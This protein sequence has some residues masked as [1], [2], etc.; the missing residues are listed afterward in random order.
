MFQ[1]P[2]LRL[3][4]P[5]NVRKSPTFHPISASLTRT[6]VLMLMTMS[7][8]TLIAQEGLS[9]KQEATLKQARSAFR[10]IKANVDLAKSTAGPGESALKGTK[11]R[12]TK[13]RLGTSATDLPKVQDL[14][15]NLPVGNADVSQFFKELESAESTIKNI[16][17]RLEGKSP[18]S[19]PKPEKEKPSKKP[20]SKPD[21][22]SMNSKS[23]TTVK[24]D[25]RQKDTLKGGQFNLREV[26]GGLRDLESIVTKYKPLKD[27]L[28]VPY[29]TI[30]QRIGV[31]QAAKR[32]LGF[33]EDTLRKL[34]DNGEGV[35]QFS[36]KIQNAKQRLNAAEEYIVRTH[37]SLQNL[38][39]PRN[40]PKL[41]ADIKRIE[42]LTQMYGNPMILLT[43]FKRSAEHVAQMQPAKK[44]VARIRSTYDRLVQQQSPE[45]TRLEKLCAYFER[46]LTTFDR[47]VASQRSQ[48]PGRI[49]QHLERCQ[50]L[51]D[52]AVK[53]KKPLFFTGGIPQELENADQKLELLSVIDQKAAKQLKQQ[54]K[55]LRV[56]LA[57]AEQRLSADIIKNNRMPEDR[58]RDTDRQ[59]VIAVAID[60]WKHQQKK[61]E[62]LAE[63]IPAE[64]WSRETMWQYS[65]GTW[66]FVDRSKLQVHLIV[67]DVKNKDQ[68]VIRPVTVI[69]NHQKGDTLIGTPIWSIKDQLTPK[70]YLLKKNVRR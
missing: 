32:K 7:A 35:N 57:S 54:I 16:Q 29:K 9:S 5:H 26:E 11:A 42:G 14:V 56:S 59:K 27:Q 66:Y 55:Q 38:V 6:F 39:D 48:L 21:S 8:N 52:Q 3:L 67:A 20:D 13:V 64:A 43:D 46:K 53:Q 40:Y 22:G 44:E 4:S 36:Q 51:A 58:Y 34:P 68:A 47:S 70:S 24:L 63:R 37:Q 12:L 10:R 69:K 50:S 31:L 19:D 23:K 62:V 25:Y 61:F 2:I 60:A 30:G 28:S 41:P 65:N 17:A 18:S 49:Q 33:A 45:G 15:A 1:H